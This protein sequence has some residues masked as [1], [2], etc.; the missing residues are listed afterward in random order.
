MAL[1]EIEFGIVFRRPENAVQGWI[2]FK[3]CIIAD[4]GTG[5]SAA[6]TKGKVHGDNYRF[7]QFFW[8]RHYSKSFWRQN[9]FP[10]SSPKKVSL[11]ICPV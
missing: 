9:T 5:G 1:L 10:H 7:S 8:N 6:R 4:T 3:T 2:F 11:R